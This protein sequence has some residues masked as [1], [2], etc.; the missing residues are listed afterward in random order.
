MSTKHDKEVQEAIRIAEIAAL[1]RAAAGI[2][3]YNTPGQSTSYLSPSEILKV[4]DKMKKSRAA[5]IFPVYF[6]DV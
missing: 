5:R 2:S 1:R 6:A 3:S 4:A